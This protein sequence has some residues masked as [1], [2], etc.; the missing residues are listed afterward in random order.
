MKTILCFLVGLLLLLCAASSYATPVSYDLSGTIH[1]VATYGD[2]GDTLF[3]QISIDYSISGTLFLDNPYWDIDYDGSDIYINYVEY[4]IVSGYVTWDDQVYDVTGS[5]RAGCSDSVGLELY[6]LASSTL[7]IHG[8]YQP[9]DPLQEPDPDIYPYL[10]D[11]FGNGANTY[12]GFPLPE[13][14]QDLITDGWDIYSVYYCDFSLTR[15][16]PVPEPAT[17]FLLGTGAICVL[18]RQRKFSKNR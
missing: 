8:D 18:S 7:S 4:D 16:T 15:T 9:Y 5:V 1:Y 14:L 6:G 2:S 13:E 11:L 3:E 17:F 12:G 10:P